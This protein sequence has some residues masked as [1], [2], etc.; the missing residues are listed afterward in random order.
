MIIEVKNL[1]KKYQKTM[2]VNGVSFSVKKG[3]VF[4]FLGPNG[5]GKTTT[6]EII[7]G[8]RKKTSGEIEVLGKNAETEI[9]EIKEKIGVQLQASTYYDY[10]SLVEI[11][12]LFGTF[13][14]KN[15]VAEK[16]LEKV[17]LLDKKN[18]K[19]S[20][21]SGGQ[22]QRFAIAASLVNDPEL[23]FL[24][25]PTTGLDPQARRYV[26]DLIREIKGEGPSTSLGASKTIVLTTHYMEEAQVLCD[27]VAIIDAGKI[28]ALDTPQKLISSL[29]APNKI[30]ITFFKECD[31]KNLEKIKGVESA[32]KIEENGHG[33][34]Y[35]LKIPKTS[36]LPKVLNWIGENNL[37][38]EDI[39][40]KSATLEDVFLQLTGKELRD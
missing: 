29:K 17:Q 11:L 23:V 40:I 10:M 12:T 13:Y 32:K 27:R 25:E 22:K 31:C 34:K 15:I 16:L 9:S 6:L 1:V 26:W 35:L 18:A 14:K 33:F 4:G 19:L 28:V 30:L 24:D 21:L 2:A 5:A 39:E 38:F 8:L 7:E 3:E 37:K 20:E 36:D